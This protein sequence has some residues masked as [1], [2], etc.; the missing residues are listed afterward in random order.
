MGSA[1]AINT[2]PGVL[3]LLMAIGQPMVAVASEGTIGTVESSSSALGREFLRDS[4]MDIL[5]G[6]VMLRPVQS[7]QERQVSG[8]NAP[9]ELKDLIQ[10]WAE[11][12]AEESE[13]DIQSNPNNKEAGTGKGGNDDLLAEVSDL[14][15]LD[16]EAS[17]NSAEATLKPACS[18]IDVSP[19]KISH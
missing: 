10:E 6:D 15:E 1:Q 16:V 17:H 5:M 12:P 13:W 11:E 19:G 4:E 3:C 7:G 2:L 18:E 8:T 9:K 14:E